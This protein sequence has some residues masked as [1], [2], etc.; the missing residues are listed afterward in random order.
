VHAL[1]QL[2]QRVV[3]VWSWL[4]AFRAVAELQH[5]NLAAKKMHIT[6]SSLSRAV[7]LLEEQVGKELFERVGRNIKLNPN[8]DA[9]LAAVRDGMRRI[10]D[11]LAR[12]NG[13]VFEGEM[14]V[15]CQ[16]DHVIGLAA[17]A[18]SALMQKH[19]EITTIVDQAPPSDELAS[20]L[21]RGDFD[22]A[23]VTEVP[24]DPRVLL[25]QVGEVRFGIYCGVGHPLYRSRK[26]STK[27]ICSHSFVAPTLNQEAGA[28]DQWPRAL[29]RKVTLRLPSLQATIAA[30]ESG[31]F[32]AV[33][34]ET[35]VAEAASTRRLRRLP[36]ESVK[37]AQLSVLRRTPTDAL[38]R[39]GAFVEALRSV[40]NRRRPTRS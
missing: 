19:R 10:D 6:P 40:V 13:T 32:L 30:C 11:G 18:A 3:A 4:P 1:T 24:S 15:V 7:R 33:L 25:D 31:A 28:V 35:A 27:L 5:V 34:P 9:L 26:V 22:L 38:D 17:R 8:G 14:R 23:I 2:Q 37:S 20:R 36:N 12:V 16:G 39:A 29:L 21:F